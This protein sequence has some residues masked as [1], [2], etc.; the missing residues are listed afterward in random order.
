MHTE[1]RDHMAGLDAE[2]SPTAGFSEHGDKP[3]SMK[4]IEFLDQMSD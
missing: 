2:G 4:N 1:G 3:D